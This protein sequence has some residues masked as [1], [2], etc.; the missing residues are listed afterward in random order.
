MAKDPIPI[1][2]IVQ[3][4]TTQIKPEP[5]TI[6]ADRLAEVAEKYK[7]KLIEIGYD[8]KVEKNIGIIARY[9]ARLRL[10]VADKGLLI[11]GATGTGKTLGMSMLK[12]F[13]PTT[14]MVPALTVATEFAEHGWPLI[15]KLASIQHEDW[16]DGFWDGK[17][18]KLSDLII[19]DLG[20][21]PEGS[22][23]GSKG[24]VLSDLISRRYRLFI[25]DGVKTHIT[26]NLT[27]DQ[28][29][30]RYGQRILSR[31][32]EMCYITAFEGEDRRVEG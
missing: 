16:S 12:R 13:F 5:K 28:I 4:A 24:D 15:K 30:Q 10:D 25:N 32:R 22:Y 7:A 23:Y 3:G 11:V 6:D 20:E 27:T 2:K 19:D 29:G 1:G 21:E 26:T 9:C 17:S 8:A 18:F 31:L 14:E